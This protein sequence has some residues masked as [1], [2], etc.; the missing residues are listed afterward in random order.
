M[1]DYLQNLVA[2]SLNLTPVAQPRVASLFEPPVTGGFF[3]AASPFETESVEAGPR[4]AEAAP[5]GDSRNTAAPPPPLT[6]RADVMRGTATSSHTPESSRASVPFNFGTSDERAA[7]SVAESTIQTQ[8]PHDRFS[9]Q[10]ASNQSEEAAAAR[11]RTTHAVEG[12]T[13]EEQVR[14]AVNAGLKEHDARAMRVASARDERAR[15]VEP[16]LAP[17]PQATKPSP[18][19]VER[20][21]QEPDAAP[22]IR[23]TIGRVHVRAVMGDAPKE[24]R[25][26]PA[27]PRP[28][29]SL[30]DYLGRRG[31]GDG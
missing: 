2:R 17:V 10:A 1:S 28:L 11:G 30:E 13:L 22:T 27:R 31:G 15:I 14:R 12:P 4:V 26:V 23:V 24:S 16:R 9:S 6:S 25:R 21:T 3:G 8:N 20:N 29:L 19:P 7:S 5:F 18:L